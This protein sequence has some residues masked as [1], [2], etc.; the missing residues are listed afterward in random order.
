MSRDASI[1]L[2]FGGASRVFRLTVV[3]AWE[4]V[5]EKCDAG[6]EELLRRYVSGTWRVHDVREVLRQALI[7][8]G[9]EVVKVDRLLKAEF[10]GLPLLQFVPVAQAV[11]MASLVGAPDEDGEPQKGELAAGEEETLSP[12]ANSTSADSTATPQ[13]PGS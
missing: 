9:L 7:H 8:G 4:K 11:V 6:P 3:P 13:G 5:Q 2:E 12:A 1:E 10:D